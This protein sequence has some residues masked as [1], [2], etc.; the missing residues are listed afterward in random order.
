[1]FSIKL[2]KNKLGFIKPVSAEDH[3]EN[4]KQLEPT[5][6][7]YKKIGRR[8]LY[9]FDWLLY[10]YENI[11]FLGVDV[12][13]I[14]KI[15][16]EKTKLAIF[17]VLIDDVSDSADTEYDTFNTEILKIPFE[18]KYIDTHKLTPTQREYIRVTKHIWDDYITTVKTFPRYGDFKRA[19]EFDVYQFINSMRYA[20][21][22]NTTPN[23]S[24]LLENR[25]YGHHSMIVILTG[26][27]DL[28]NIKT[29][30][31]EE[32]PKIR[33]ILYY[34]QQLARIGNMM[35][36]YPRE[37]IEKDV[38][39]EIMT[40]AIENKALSREAIQN[41]K[42]T[43]EKLK[44]ISKLENNFEKLWA[45]LYSEIEKTGKEIKSLDVKEFLKERKFI[46]DKY[47][48]RVQYWLTKYQNKLYV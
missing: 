30:D 2:N 17:D 19:F 11:Y 14:N 36:T 37:I 18:S 42:N 25:T 9:L 32:F 39:S 35:N 27:M 15:A 48:T 38:S 22:V 24:N 21:F 6:K 40:L 8:N 16:V 45:T 46:Q 3:K 34:S 20:H 23:V 41:D 29:F 47:N 31:L 10:M 1:M 12:K 7:L 26:L 43:Q 13:L 44:K 33:K 28:M 4:W 5:I